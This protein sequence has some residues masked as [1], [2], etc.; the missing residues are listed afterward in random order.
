[1]I[2]PGMLDQV[3]LPLKA[4]AAEILAEAGKL[5]PRGA[6]ARPVA[7][8]GMRGLRVLGDHHDSW[9]RLR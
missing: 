1:M 4:S 5:R 8:Q 2:A 7:G 6:A 9:R 3:R